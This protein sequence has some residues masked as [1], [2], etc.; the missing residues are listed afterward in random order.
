MQLIVFSEFI[1]LVHSVGV[2]H[3]MDIDRD[4]KGM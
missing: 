4:L 3:G 2:T 1:T